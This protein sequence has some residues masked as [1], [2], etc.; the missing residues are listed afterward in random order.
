MVAMVFKAVAPAGNGN[1]LGVVQETI[2]DGTG[3]GHVAQR[4]AP[5]LHRPVVGHNGGAIFIP[6]HDRFIMSG[7]IRRLRRT[8]IR[9]ARKNIVPLRFITGDCP[10]Q[11]QWN[12]NSSLSNSSLAPCRIPANLDAEERNKTIM[13]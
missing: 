8:R 11:A 3:R 4:F 12:S 1:G 5:F 6:A 2:Q 13:A 10:L 9:Q 7:G